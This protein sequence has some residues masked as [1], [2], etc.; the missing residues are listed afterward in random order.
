MKLFLDTHIFPW[1]AGDDR[2]PPSS[3]R[4]AIQNSENDV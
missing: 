1:H 2:Q 3:I 4:D